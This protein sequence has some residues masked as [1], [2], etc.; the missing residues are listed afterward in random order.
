[1][2]LDRL[3][4]HFDRNGDGFLSPAEAA[5]IFPLPLDG[6]RTVAMNFVALDTD[7]DGKGSRDEFRA[8]YLQN[9]F[10]PLAV[11]TR[12]APTEALALG[13]TLFR[14]LDRDGDGRL[15]RAEVS[16]ATALLRRFDDDEDEVLTASELLAQPLPGA[17]L[18][19]VGL[20]TASVKEGVPN[21]RVLR[22]S[23]GGQP[24]LSGGDPFRLSTDGSRLQVPGGT[25]AL[26]V[27]ADDPLPGFR[28]ARTFYEA[29]FKAVADEKGVTKKT[30]AEDPSAGVL[31]RLFDAADRNGDG[32]LTRAELEAFFDLVELGLTSRIVVTVTDRGRNLFDLF[33]RNGDGRLDLGELTQ[34][35]R[36]LLGNLTG[37]KQLDRLSIPASYRLSLGHG[38]FAG[39]FGPV[40]FGATKQGKSSMPAAVKGPRW[41]RAM[42][43]N[44]DGFVSR[45]EFIGP[46]ALFAELD[47]DGDDRISAEE[48]ELADRRVRPVPRQNGK[49]QRTL[50]IRKDPPCSAHATNSKVSS[51][52][53]NSAE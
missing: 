28:A 47:A 5:R 51:S 25:C 3:F 6:T 44:G 27:G 48:A 32:I 37:E 45:Q 30:F 11:I 26:A 14:H 39:S 23:I 10:T 9:G 31:I 46:P 40:R 53:S 15:S 38:T 8:F 22:L 49:A 41:F 35:S 52:P 29:Q 12:P 21:S 43:R 18:Q 33:D 36:T 4:D 34:G 16:Q 50:S 2:F 19:P 7:R 17:E 13:E 20:G 1:V 42:D 24:S